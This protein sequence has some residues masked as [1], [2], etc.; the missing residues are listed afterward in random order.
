MR[1]SVCSKSFIVPPRATRFAPGPISDFAISRGFIE[2]MGGSIDAA[3]RSDRPGAVFTINLPVPKA[4]ER[5]D[6][7]A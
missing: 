7:A 1:S 4:V 2:A 3:N 6:T 5:L